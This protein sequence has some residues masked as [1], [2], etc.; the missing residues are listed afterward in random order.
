MPYRS[1]L[2]TYEIQPRVS[3]WKKL[4]DAR[5]MSDQDVM[6]LNRGF[7]MEERLGIIPTE[8]GK[9]PKDAQGNDRIFIMKKNEK[10]RDVPMSLEDAGLELGS[11]AFWEQARLGNV[12]AYPA[13]DADPVQI[14]PLM[15]N[16]SG[17][18]IK[19]SRP[20]KP[21]DLPHAPQPPKPNFWNRLWRRVVKSYQ[22]KINNYEN[23]I[24]D[25][26]TN[27]HR[28]SEMA[29]SRM[30]NDLQAE[31]DKARAD[32]KIIALKKK[33][34]R[35]L[36]DVKTNGEKVTGMDNGM[37]LYGPKPRL[38]QTLLKAE[39]KTG[40]YS[41]QEFDA[42]ETFDD[43]EQIRIGGEGISDEDFAALS[44]LASCQPKFQKESPLISTYQ[45]EYGEKMQELF[46]LSEEEKNSVVAYHADTN[47]TTDYLLHNPRQ[48]NGRAI[49]K[50]VA[51]AKREVYAMLKKY[52]PKDPASKQDLA[53]LIAFGVKR[54]ANRVSAQIS[55]FRD[56]SFNYF[57]LAGRAADLLERDPD[58]K[59]MAFEAGL[60]EAD[61]ACV[62]GM[63]A[64][65]EL[66]SKRFEAK[67]ALYQAGAEGRELDPETRKGYLRDI[68]K[69]NLAEQTI[70]MQV[71]QL[72]PAG[73]GAAYQ[74]ML[75]GFSKD[76]VNLE[77]RGAIE[78]LI[79]EMYSP[80]PQLAEQLGTNKNAE[81]HL[82]KMADLII[83]KDGLMDVPSGEIGLKVNQ[84]EY[85]ESTVVDKANSALQENQRN[86][87]DVIPADQKIVDKNINEAENAG[88]VKR[89]VL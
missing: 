14:L 11:R 3:D 32:G 69:A 66:D 9:V 84:N 63:V 68:L 39:G 27:P 13:G 35:A 6:L 76:Q 34:Q 82:E 52:D 55:S 51:P 57:R 88:P 59:K 19:Y 79:K 75:D 41:Q 49:P 56:C 73:K 70:I 29:V 44:M 42:L 80:H 48:N 2:Y 18:E 65:D 62:K 26:Q 16:M 15:K 24:K 7:R 12:F 78:A 77:Q 5:K 17:A 31:A 54:S 53:K 83:E 30:Q 23:W 86:E 74:E 8:D 38:K 50:T 67:K 64:L 45:V 33:N 28:L 37:S 36:D 43:V 4:P 1:D 81:K 87:P 58:L 40:L 10:G 21:Q 72:K 46:G 60:S 47:T 22:E 25:R 71:K 61:I 20:I 89:S 85:K